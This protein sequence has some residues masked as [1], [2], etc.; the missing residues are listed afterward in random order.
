M[1]KGPFKIVGP[2]LVANGTGSGTFSSPDQSSLST[3]LG[4]NNVVEPAGSLVGKRFRLSGLRVRRNS[5]ASKSFELNFY[6]YDYTF[7]NATANFQLLATYVFPATTPVG[8]WFTM[9]EIVSGAV[10]RASANEISQSYGANGTS[11]SG[12][13]FTYEGLKV[14]EVLGE[15]DSA[16]RLEVEAT[17]TGLVNQIENPSGAL[18][19]FG[20]VT[21]VA[22][23]VLVGDV[24]GLSYTTASR[25]GGNFFYGEPFAVA[26]GQYVAARW[27][28][29]YTP[30]GCYRARFDWLDANQVQISQG[31]WLTETEVPQG[32]SASIAAT[33]APTS[34]V[35][36]RLRFEVGNNNGVYPY[37]YGGSNFSIRDV[38]VAKASTPAALSNL[39][40]IETVKYTDVLGPTHEIRTVR[41]DLNVGTLN[42]TILDSTLD[43]ATAS[44]LRPGR[45]CRLTSYNAESSDFEP[46]FSG[47]LTAADV[48]Y[49]LPRLAAMPGDVRHARIS[50][51]AVDPVQ[52]L[53]NSSRPDGVAEVR[54]LPAVFE[55]T[56]VPWVVNGDSNHVTAPAI[57]KNA[58]AS[59][60]DQLAIVRDSRHGYAWV[61]RFGV[62]Q[63]WTTLPDP[64]IEMAP[65]G[66][67]ESNLANWFGE[68]VGAN[69]TLT[70]D[71]AVKSLGLASA[72]LTA[73]AGVTQ[74][75]LGTVNT[76]TA[77]RGRIAVTPGATYVVSAKVRAGTTPRAI[78]VFV[79]WWDKPGTTS[80][81]ISSSGDDFENPN[82][83]TD[84]VGVWT[85][86]SQTVTAPAGATAADIGFNVYVPSGS[87]AMPAGEAHYF[88]EVS[89]KAVFPV[90]V[91][92]EDDYGNLDVSFN[93]DD[94]INEVTIRL[95]RK[96][97]ATGETVEV[98][99]GPYINQASVDQ[100]GAHS[101][102]FTVQGL[103]DSAAAMSAFA[104]EVFAANA[105][106][107]V[108]VNSVTMPIRSVA[109]L[110]TS[111]A[112]VDLYALVRVNNAAKGLNQKSRVTVIEHSIT[113]DKWLTTLKF[114]STDSVAAPQITPAVQT[115]LLDDAT[116]Q[117]GTGSA[118]G[119]TYGPGWSNFGANGFFRFKL[120]PDGTTLR[121]AFD[122]TTPGGNNVLA[123]TFPP[124]YRPL[125]NIL[126]N[127]AWHNATGNPV[128]T[129]NLL[130][131]GEFRY[132]G[133][134]ASA[135]RTIGTMVLPLDM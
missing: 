108:R 96:N 112:L 98:P 134:G 64:D 36:A 20:W 65:N 62:V 93:T 10:I 26:A 29:V 22:G 110:T 8:Q 6:A 18:G 124:G 34:T 60:L 127:L 69:A 11:G 54:E 3:G 77:T 16:I 75:R 73:A 31:G 92:D 27:L 130:S 30:H 59:A 84:A 39:D 87:A 90:A 21:P 120:S 128:C 32:R 63:A 79:D 24:Y 97:L 116:H 104:A 91:L 41:E 12:F 123:V 13:D 80:T 72:K 113:P 71:T 45:R 70:R 109:D 95:L 51:T 35:Y 17:P 125:N 7:G 118:L 81:F 61:D 49:D 19:G 48:T 94:C 15:T 115:M 126:N 57:T 106:P 89:M 28:Q 43:P 103:T 76:S 9:P 52:R 53:A 111:K 14:Q 114:A 68:G 99:Y 37:T 132:Y 100:W 122:L 82:A 4:T 67:F 83:Q 78:P 1:I 5:A 44:T 25:A 66:G 131:T 86:V 23:S 135:T 117:I 33:I 55:G 2:N 129:F 102:E 133:L 38:T 88:D 50:L 101:S 40:F 58:S 107:E 46:I 42:A 85:T 105:T 74:M 119:V 121:L 56:G 47:R